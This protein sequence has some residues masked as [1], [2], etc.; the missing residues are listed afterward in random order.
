MATCEERGKRLLKNELFFEMCL[1]SFILTAYLVASPFLGF[2]VDIDHSKGTVE[3]CCCWKGMSKTS[4]KKGLGRLD[5]LIFCFLW[6]CETMNPCGVVCCEEEKEKGRMDPL[7]DW[8]DLLACGVNDRSTW[9]MRSWT[10]RIVVGT[11]PVRGGSTKLEEIRASK[12]R[13]TV[14]KRVENFFLVLFIETQRK[15]TSRKMKIL[16]TFILKPVNMSR[17]GSAFTLPLRLQFSLQSCQ[18]P[19]VSREQGMS[20]NYCSY[21]SN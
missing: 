3:L 13:G 20:N 11:R 8:A 14:L 18:T 15:G 12:Q 19:L 5:I 6:S 4:N 21:F 2:L 17:T 9:K 1:F 7:G 16:G 10:G